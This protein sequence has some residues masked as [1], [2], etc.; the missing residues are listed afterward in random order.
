MIDVL[1]NS[2]SVVLS[3][4][5]ADDIERL[6]ACN[7]APFTVGKSSPRVGLE[8]GTSIYISVGRCLTR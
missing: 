4:R 5:W 1:F 8:P 3:G 6:C 7:G 2:F